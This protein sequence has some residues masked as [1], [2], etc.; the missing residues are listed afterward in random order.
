[1]RAGA[2]A[3]AY[4]DASMTAT[5]MRYVAAILLLCALSLVMAMSAAGRMHAAMERGAVLGQY[6]APSPDAMESHRIFCRGH[7]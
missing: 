6:C 1:M 3:S 2:G 4:G 5:T 7:G